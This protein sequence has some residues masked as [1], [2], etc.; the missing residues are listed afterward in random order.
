MK[1]KT[2]KKTKKES[3]RA[4]HYIIAVPQNYMCRRAFLGELATDWSLLS[5]SWENEDRTILSVFMQ[6]DKNSLEPSE[7]EAFGAVILDR[8]FI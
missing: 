5:I 2:K 6:G 1:N 8:H 7:V 4:I 3:V